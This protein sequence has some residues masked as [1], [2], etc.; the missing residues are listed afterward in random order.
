MRTPAPG[1]G[2]GRCLER[3]LLAASAER[4][5]PRS[6]G[7]VDPAAKRRS[8]HPSLGAPAI[9]GMRPSPVEGLLHAL[10]DRAVVGRPGQL[11]G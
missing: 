2:L 11:H 10:G 9:P 1:S 3:M 6:T 5:H 7:T 8:E 4:Q